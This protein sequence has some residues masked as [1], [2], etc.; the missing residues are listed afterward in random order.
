V[1]TSTV[2]DVKVRYALDDRASRG[3]GNI[4]SA[5]DRAA[6]KTFSL[7]GAMAALGAGAAFAVGKKFLIDYNNEIDKMR[8]GM[9]TII[10]MQF[11]KPFEE[12]RTEADKLFLR[13]QE[14]AKKSPSTTKD[15]IQMGSALAPVVAMLGGGTDKIEKFAQ[16]ALLAAMATGTQADV[17]AND[18][19]GMLLGQVEKPDKMANQL[20]A[21]R[22]LNSKDFNAMS[23]MERARIVESILQ[24]PALLRSAE[25]FG[26]SFAGTVSTFQDQLEIALGQV[27]KPLMSALT[28]EVSKWN[29]WIEKHPRTLQRIASELGSMLTSSFEYARSAAG[30]LV[31]NQDTLMAVAKTF[32]VFKGASLATNVF[33]QFAQG[34]AGLVEKLKTAGST[35]AAA[36]AGGG[37]GGL[38]GAFRG[39]VGLLSGAGGVIPVFATLAGAAWQ[40]FRTFT[41]INDDAAGRGRRM[42]FREAL[43][44]AG[45][46]TTRLRELDKL[47]ASKPGQAKP[48]DK[49][50]A[51]IRDRLTTERAK[52][53]AQLADPAVMG[54]IL[55]AVSEAREK[56]GFGGFAGMSR[57]HFDQVVSKGISAGEF[58]KLF[59]DNAEARQLTSELHDTYRAFA[60]MDALTRNSVF[61]AAFPE[62]FP[63][64]PKS[65]LPT[66]QDLSSWMPQAPDKADVKVTI[67]KIEVASEDPDRFVHGLVRAA[68]QGLKNPTQAASTIPGG[69]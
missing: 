27:G 47:F 32:L 9:S 62:Q 67:H 20:L 25:E 38:V 52:L 51:D 56:H 49:M 10:S 46:A 1:S 24:D 68:T 15:F 50:D 54:P 43:G 28:V 57:E 26:K 69:F 31:E 63:D 22:G 8:I 58:G 30:W 29:A 18:V 65:E 64:Q 40:L 55:R 11:K 48:I 4:A 2:Y 5:A 34:A 14:L 41:D 21:S 42:D 6:Q 61:R 12:A 13:F 66:Q 23:A 53:R 37:S 33:S 7:K 19:K 35:V 3:M 44:V 59:A 36:V 60:S 39:L 16:G 17:A 45:D